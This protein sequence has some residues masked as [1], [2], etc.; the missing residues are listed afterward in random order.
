MAAIRK[1]ILTG[2]KM[3]VKNGEGL[4]AISAAEVRSLAAAQKVT[5]TKLQ[6]LLDAWRRNGNG[7]R[8]KR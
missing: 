5:E 6:N 4:Q 2:M 1:L 3:I 8:P 7:H